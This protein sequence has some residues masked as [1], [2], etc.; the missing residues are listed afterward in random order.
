[1][2]TEEAKQVA[3]RLG[4]STWQA[5]VIKVGTDSSETAYTN[6]VGFASISLPIAEAETWEEAL[7][8]AM[9]IIFTA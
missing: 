2:T 4:M 6:C 1:M 8:E 3:E 5:E 7:N 9:R